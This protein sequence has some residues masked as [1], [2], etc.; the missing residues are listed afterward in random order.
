MSFSR[1]GNKKGG[2]PLQRN[3]T[4]ACTISKA[5]CRLFRFL[6]SWPLDGKCASAIG[7][8]KNRVSNQKE[9]FRRAAATPIFPAK[10]KNGFSQNIPPPCSQ[11]GY[12]D[13]L[14]R[15]R[16]FQAHFSAF[17][18]EPLMFTKPVVLLDTLRKTF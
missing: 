2:S 6:P 3:R 4:P 5:D 15:I 18:S 14:N 1:S 9:H 7:G 11:K 17:G 13:F 10:R 12:S 8:R 16:R